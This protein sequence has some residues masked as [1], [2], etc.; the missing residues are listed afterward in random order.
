MRCVEG[1]KTYL[2]AASV[3]IDSSEHFRNLPCIKE[4]NEYHDDTEKNEFNYFCQ[5][6]VMQPLNEV[7]HYT[8]ITRYNIY[9]LLLML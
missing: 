4:T 2:Q 7:Y 1:S 3:I 5:V 8:N 9:K 6:L